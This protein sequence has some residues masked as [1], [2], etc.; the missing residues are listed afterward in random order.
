[1]LTTSI[2]ADTFYLL[3]IKKGNRRNAQNRKNI[4]KLRNLTTAQRFRSSYSILS[5]VLL[6]EFTSRPEKFSCVRP[7]LI[8]NYPA[9]QIT[10]RTRPQYMGI[11]SDL[12][13][14]SNMTCV[15]SE[16]NRYG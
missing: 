11:V 9:L 2:L 5:A 13:Y 6:H 15:S 1:M 16:N 4:N 12:I 10:Y 7:Q 3:D 14:C 8:E